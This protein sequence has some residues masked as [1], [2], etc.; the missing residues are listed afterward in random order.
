MPSGLSSP[1]CVGDPEQQSLA[2]TLWLDGLDSP[3]TDEILEIY[4]AIECWKSVLVD[5]V[6]YP[7]EIQASAF[8]MTLIKD[9][10][11]SFSR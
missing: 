5:T 4:L 3:E 7:R 6:R 2:R 9:R 10:A 8:G 11:S 1:C